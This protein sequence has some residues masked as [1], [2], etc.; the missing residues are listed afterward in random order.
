MLSC[1]R[2]NIIPYIK[3]F[4]CDAMHTSRAPNLLLVAKVASCQVMDI[5]HQRSYQISYR[6]LFNVELETEITVK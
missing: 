6:K 4:I 3:D 1:V 5:V 2:N